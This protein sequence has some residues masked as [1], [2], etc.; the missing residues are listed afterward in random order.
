MLLMLVSSF[1]CV[2][3]VSVPHRQQ[4]ASGVLSPVPSDARAYVVK[5]EGENDDCH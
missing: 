1:L 4:S 5:G 3:M 2:T